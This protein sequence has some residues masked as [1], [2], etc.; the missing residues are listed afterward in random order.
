MDI[1]WFLAI[2]Q[3]AVGLGV[4]HMDR[5]FLVAED[6]VVYFKAGLSGEHL[7][8]RGVE[9]RFGGFSLRI[10]NR[11]THVGLYAARRR[12]VTPSLKETDPSIGIELTAM[13]RIAGTQDEIHVKARTTR[14]LPRCQDQAGLSKAWLSRSEVTSASAAHQPARS[15][16]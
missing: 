3:S 15:K 13:T 7:D 14:V 10:E 2:K 5:V 1:V 8:E 11:R 16:A 4:H 6:G 9:V 12:D